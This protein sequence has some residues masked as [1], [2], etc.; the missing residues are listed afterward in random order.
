MFVPGRQGERRHQAKPRQRHRRR[1]DVEV[2]PSRQPSQAH[3]KGNKSACRGRPIMPG[4]LCRHQP[5]V[6]DGPGRRD[7]NHGM[8]EWLGQIQQGPRERLGNNHY[9][10]DARKSCRGRRRSVGAPDR[11]RIR[12]R[13]SPPDGVARALR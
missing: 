2:A 6:G 13:N 11:E 10:W 1:G 5:H 3:G 8:L 9:R 7:K 4:L 12:P